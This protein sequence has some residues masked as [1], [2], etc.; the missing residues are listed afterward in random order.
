MRR[1]HVRMQ[2][3]QL[4][5][6]QP[7]AFCISRLQQVSWLEAQ[8]GK[9]MLKLTFDATCWMCLAEATVGTSRACGTIQNESFLP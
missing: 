1:L 4:G 9:H 7:K 8:H 3:K 5:V 2:W 6:E